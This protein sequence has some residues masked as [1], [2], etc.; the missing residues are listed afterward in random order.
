VL[1]YAIRDKSHET[2]SSKGTNMCGAEPIEAFF[3]GTTTRRA[4]SL[5]RGFLQ[6]LDR[7][8]TAD[9]AKIGIDLLRW[10]FEVLAPNGHLCPLTG[11]QSRHASL[12]PMGSNGWKSCELYC[13]LDWVCNGWC[14][15][16]D[17]S[18]SEVFLVTCLE[19][20]EESS[21]PADRCQLRAFVS[22][23]QGGFGLPR[24]QPQVDSR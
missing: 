6:A 5:H 16:A 11:L 10:R 20:L 23:L 3:D 15:A 14:Q 18:D 8:L 7:S 1:A 21:D 9:A 4:D 19:V 2:F 17:G 12:V 22:L 13:V 24:I